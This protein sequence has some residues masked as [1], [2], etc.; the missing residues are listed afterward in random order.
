V[1]LF[2]SA[3]LL[4]VCATSAGAVTITFED[5]TLG[6][7]APVS[8]G[9]TLSGGF[10]TQAGNISSLAAVE[11]GDNGTQ[12]FQVDDAIL[13]NSGGCG[14]AGIVLEAFDGGAF[15]FFGADTFLD[16]SLDFANIRI[17]GTKVGGGSATGAIGTG[18]WLNLEQVTFLAT[19][20]SEIGIFSPTF[21]VDNIVVGAAVPI[22]AAVWLFGS[23][24]AGL[25]WLRRKQTI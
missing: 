19:A 4:S 16:V 2:I 24:L 17:I 21:E 9:F 25:G 23:A 20:S 15:S 1:K 8:Q 6:D 5:Q 10:Q 22:P 11:I 7:T 14:A 12:V 18:D 3:I 13:C